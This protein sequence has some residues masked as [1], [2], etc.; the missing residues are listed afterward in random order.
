MSAEQTVRIENATTSGNPVFTTGTVNPAITGVY[1]HSIANVSGTVASQNFITL[2]NPVGSGKSLS[3]GTVAISSTNTTPSTETSPL[4]GW[5][6]SSAPTGGTLIAASSMARFNTLQ[7][8]PVGV[9]RV[10]NPAATLDAALFSSPPLVDHRSSIVHTV[11]IPPGAGPFL[12]RPGEGLVINK[13]V[14]VIS[15]SWNITVVWAEI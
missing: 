6:T 11:D 1:L 15:T 12:F 5:R 9:I 4:R 14:D 3:L 13:P 10:D 2:F 8:D 7:A